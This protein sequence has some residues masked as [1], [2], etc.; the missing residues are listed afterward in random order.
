MKQTHSYTA[1]H[2][3]NENGFPL[4]WMC[5]C[6]I[7]SG[8]T[9]GLRDEIEEHHLRTKVQPGKIIGRPAGHVAYPKRATMQYQP[10]SPDT[11]Q[12]NSQTG[13]QKEA[14]EST[15]HS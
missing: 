8:A 2:Y 7:T 5:R 9:S 11:T 6:C 13:E 4:S 14:T 15:S 10:Q 1:S 12:Q 3:V